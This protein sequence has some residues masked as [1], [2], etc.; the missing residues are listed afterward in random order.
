MEF[1]REKA[2]RYEKAG[3]PTEAEEFINEFLNVFDPSPQ[4]PIRRA[5]AN[6]PTPTMNWRPWVIE[7]VNGTPQRN[8]RNRQIGAN[9]P[10]QPPENEA[11]DLPPANHRAANSQQNIP[12]K[13]NKLLQPE[14]NDE[15]YGSNT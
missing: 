2:S 13:P 15:G 1:V 7:H 5:R 12:A 11:H 9:R 6:P 3:S 10:L 14:E 4:P 8:P